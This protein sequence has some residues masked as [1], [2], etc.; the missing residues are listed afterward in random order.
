MGLNFKLN[1]AST[2]IRFVIMALCIYASTLFLSAFF[3]GIVN[4][5]NVVALGFLILVFMTALF[6]RQLIHLGKQRKWFRYAVRAW[7]ALATL[8]VV[9]GA[10]LS[11]FML[12]SAVPRI[13]PPKTVI[14]LGCQIYGEK[15]SVM[16]RARLDAAADYLSDNPEA[17]CVVSGGQGAD[18]VIPEAQAMRNYLLAIGV[19]GG[20]IIVEDRSTSTKENI[21]FSREILSEK[22]LLYDNVAIATDGYHQARAGLVAQKCGFSEVYPISSYSVPAAVPTLWVRE[23]FAV[24]AYAVFGMI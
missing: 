14:V 11:G 21:D 1:K 16:L 23:W 15:P 13:E 6:W 20:R 22:G 2:W 8:V 18:E 17:V 10:I 19:D 3:I 7:T 9:W 4:F 24:F 12:Y 5:A